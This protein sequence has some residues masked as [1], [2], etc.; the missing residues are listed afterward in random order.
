MFFRESSP[1]KRGEERESRSRNLANFAAANF[2]AGVQESGESGD[3][4]GDLIKFDKTSQRTRTATDGH[5]KSE[6]RSLV[7]RELRGS[8]KRSD[9][10]CRWREKEQR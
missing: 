5:E 8:V 2:P 10:T 4:R 7:N 6:R 3:A 9:L 1:R